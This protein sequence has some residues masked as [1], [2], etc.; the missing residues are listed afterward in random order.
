MLSSSTPY[1][2]HMYLHILTKQHR[3]VEDHSRIIDLCICETAGEWV[4]IWGR[5][6]HL[7]WIWECIVLFVMSMPV[8]KFSIKCLIQLLYVYFGKCHI[9]W[10]F[11]I[12]LWYVVRWL[13]ET[14]PYHFAWRSL[15]QIELYQ[16]ASVIISTYSSRR[17]VQSHVWGIDGYCYLHYWCALY[18]TSPAYFTWS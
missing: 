4:I 18:F 3:V 2:I 12:V 14:W 8:L 15:S 11:T 7:G 16:K 17:I 1:H 10:R 5:Y 6:I 9:Q 13:C